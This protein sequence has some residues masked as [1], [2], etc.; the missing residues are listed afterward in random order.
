MNYGQ[1]VVSA[2]TNFWVGGGIDSKWKKKQLNYKMTFVYLQNLGN[3]PA[4]SINNRT[5]KY[6]HF[7]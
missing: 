2:D 3:W 1:K 6:T 7:L 4:D 5:E